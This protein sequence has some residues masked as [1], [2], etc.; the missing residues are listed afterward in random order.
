MSQH[1]I[2]G[3]ERPGAHVVVRRFAPARRPVSDRVLI[4]IGACTIAV[5]LLVALSAVLP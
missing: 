5:S 3:S 2:I 1:N 4:A